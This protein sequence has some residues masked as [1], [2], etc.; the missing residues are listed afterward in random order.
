MSKKIKLKTRFGTKIKPKIDFGTIIGIF[1][2]DLEKK[3]LEP[4]LN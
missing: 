1:E 2:G 4:K 3:D